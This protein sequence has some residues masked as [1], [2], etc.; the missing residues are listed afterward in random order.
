[1]QLQGLLHQKKNRFAYSFEDVIGFHDSVE[2]VVVPYVSKLNEKERELGLERLETMGHE[3]CTLRE[4][5]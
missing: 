1:L 5:A 3:C 4:G 2:K